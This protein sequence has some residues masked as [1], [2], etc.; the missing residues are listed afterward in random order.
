M[1]LLILTKTMYLD[2]V[3]KTHNLNYKVNN[4]NILILRTNEIN[5]FLLFQF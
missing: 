2:V 5:I 1:E 3:R 4:T